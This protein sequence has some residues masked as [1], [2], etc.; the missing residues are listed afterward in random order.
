MPMVYL[1]DR[2]TSVGH[3]EG[4]AA[5]YRLHKAVQHHVLEQAVGDHHAAPSLPY[6]R[7][8]HCMA[9]PYQLA[10]A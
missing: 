1:R 8:H 2:E 7:A 5:D 4:K 9:K 3:K 6:Q 10:H